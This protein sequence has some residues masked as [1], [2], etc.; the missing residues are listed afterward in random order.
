[1]KTNTNEEISFTNCYVGIYLNK[2]EGVIAID[3]KSSELVLY[4]N[5][6]LYQSLAWLLYN[7]SEYKKLMDYINWE[8]DPKSAHKSSIIEVHGPDHAAC[9]VCPL[10]HE[11]V[12]V[13]LEIGVSIDLKFADFKGLIDLVNEAQND[14]EW[15][16]E[17]LKWTFNK[18]I[19]DIQITDKRDKD[20]FLAG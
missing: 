17:L 7:A 16:R 6:S 19:N 1:M 20:N 2:N 3:F 15:R 5:T 4:L 10:N 13:N 14:L 11:R 9:L 18:Q 8:V 12:Q